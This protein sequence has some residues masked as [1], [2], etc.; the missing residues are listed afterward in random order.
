M[1]LL[2]M[3]VHRVAWEGSKI[4]ELSLS[5]G[6]GPSQSCHREHRS[7]KRCIHYYYYV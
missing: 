6:I 5:R 7:M 1:D 2:L 3:I 4:S